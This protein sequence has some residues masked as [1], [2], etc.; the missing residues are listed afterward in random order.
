M[1]LA[2]VLGLHYWSVAGLATSELPFYLCWW[3]LPPFP[4]NLLF[5]SSVALLCGFS[6][7]LAPAE[8]LQHALAG[9]VGLTPNFEVGSH[10]VLAPAGPMAGLLTLSIMP[11]PNGE[12]TTWASWR[13]SEGN[14]LLFP[15]D[16]PELSSLYVASLPVSPKSWKFHSWLLNS[17]I[18]KI[19]AVNSST[20]SVISV[21]TMSKTGGQQKV[22]FLE[23]V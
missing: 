21:T 16:H 11:E 15:Q 17:Q 3:W 18:I 14:L 6:L 8:S 10:L 7:P 4:W 23:F 19:P 13:E 1:F 20:K 9:L 2:E 22:Q 5:F 12:V